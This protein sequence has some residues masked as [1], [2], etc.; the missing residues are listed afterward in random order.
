MR[1]ASSWNLERGVE[2]KG[3]GKAGARK[4]PGAQ[5]RLAHDSR[6]H[7]RSEKYGN[8]LWTEGIMGWLE[9]RLF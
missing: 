4:L 1:P 5:A 8:A 7:H 2:R 3:E 9:V 6:D